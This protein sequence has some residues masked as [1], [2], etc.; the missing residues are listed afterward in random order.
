MIELEIQGLAE[1][2]E[3]LLI[4]V[5]RFILATGFTLRRQRLVHDPHGILLTVVVR[6]SARK[7]RALEKLLETCERLIS[8]KISPLVEGELKPHFAA[9]L[10]QS[11]YR[12]PVL[13]VPVGADPSLIAKP[14]AQTA[15]QHADQPLNRPAGPHVDQSTGQPTEPMNP[16]GVNARQVTHVWEAEPDFE[17]IQPIQREPVIERVARVEVTPFIEVVP[18][19]PDEAAVDK[20]LRSL[21]YDYPHLLL[22][23]LLTLRAEVSQAALEASLELA[24]RR[25]G[26]WVFAREYALDAGLDLLDAISRIGVPALRALVEVDQRDA[27]LHILDSPLCTADG[28]SGCSFFLGFLKGLLEPAVATHTVSIFPVCCRSYGADECVLAISD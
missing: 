14:A 8:F 19:E 20:A 17:F 7:Q 22:P 9:S 11:T 2:R 27:Q 4:E 28:H 15:H 25:A 16:A 6:G 13:P 21:E 18:L 10:P 26:A 3:G 23:R 12:P 24:G 1:S 5:S